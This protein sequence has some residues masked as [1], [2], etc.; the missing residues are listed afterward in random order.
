[1]RAVLYKM[2][3]T[4]DFWVSGPEPVLYKR[5]KMADFGLWAG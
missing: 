5:P 1:M 4:Q 2:K 3:K